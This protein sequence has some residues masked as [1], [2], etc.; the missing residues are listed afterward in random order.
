V[1]AW[2][3][4]FRALTSVFGFRPRSWRNVEPEY[5]AHFLPEET[6]AHKDSWTYR[7]MGIWALISPRR[8]S[9]L[10]ENCRITE[11]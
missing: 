5:R 10:E 1:P 4:P 6:M 9:Q 11:A 7:S 3:T 2:K 8:D